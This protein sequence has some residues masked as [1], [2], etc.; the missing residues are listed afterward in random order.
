MSASSKR[1]VAAKKLVDHL[2]KALT[3]AI[4]AIPLLILCLFE[5]KQTISQVRQVLQD[6]V[7]FERRRQL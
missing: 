7:R 6:P 1:K 4:Y 5:R 3:V 2:A